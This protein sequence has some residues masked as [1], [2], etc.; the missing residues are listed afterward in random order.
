[1]TVCTNHVAL[2]DLVEDRLPFAVADAFGDVEALG[3]EVVELED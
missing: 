1:M 2:G 3:C